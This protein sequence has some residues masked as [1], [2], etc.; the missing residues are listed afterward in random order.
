MLLKVAE[1]KR[2]QTPPDITESQT[3]RKQCNVW[4][5]MS[6]LINLSS[7]SRL[8]N[9]IDFRKGIIRLFSTFSPHKINYNV[10]NEISCEVV[11]TI[12]TQKHLKSFFSFAENSCLWFLRIFCFVGLVILLASNLLNCA[13]LI[14][15][16][17]LL[18]PLFEFLY[19]DFL[20]KNV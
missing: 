19:L 18:F 4:L 7:F 12:E 1:L 5:A 14:E 2:V 9:K 13:Y 11:Q 8:C 15:S 10:H 3:A 16:L 17:C 20:I 6:K